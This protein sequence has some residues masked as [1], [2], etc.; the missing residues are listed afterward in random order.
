MTKFKIFENVLNEYVNHPS[1]VL[2]GE[3]EANSADE[4]V[5]IFRTMNPNKGT[6]TVDN[7][8]YD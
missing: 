7:K 5:K 2:V 6:L 3:V 4:A 1:Q 8:Q